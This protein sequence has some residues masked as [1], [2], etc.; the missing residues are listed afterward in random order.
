MEKHIVIFNKVSKEY[1]AVVSYNSL[2]QVDS[3][4]FTTKIVEFDESTHE[5]NGGNFDDG[6]VI[7]KGSN[8]PTTTESTLDERCGNSIT[9]VYKPHHELNAIINVLSEI[10]EKENMS[11]EAVDK[12]KEITQFI[13]NRRMINDRYKSAFQNDPNWNYITKEQE[14]EEIG[15][16]YD[17]GLYEQINNNL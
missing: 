11:S 2:D 1:F 7:V 5:W 16:L 3:K 6:Q 17:G 14:Q 15:R 12:F 10:I 8:V 4:F 13:A 9:E